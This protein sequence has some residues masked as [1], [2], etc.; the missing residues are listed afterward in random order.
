MP[1]ITAP[2]SPNIAM[3]WN[4]RH[5][6]R[7][8]PFQ[9]MDHARRLVD[10]SDDD[11]LDVPRHRPDGLDWQQLNVHERPHVETERVHGGRE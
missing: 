3:M 2:K 7:T 4:L 6:S 5:H 9:K 10:T 8:H 1:L 11:D